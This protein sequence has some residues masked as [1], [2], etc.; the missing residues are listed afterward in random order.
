MI[1][2]VAVALGGLSFAFILAGAFLPAI[3]CLALLG[4]LNVWM[5]GGD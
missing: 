4:A 3:I 1:E 5:L 2:V